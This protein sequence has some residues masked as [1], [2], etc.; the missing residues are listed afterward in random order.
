MRS[1]QQVPN[2]SRSHVLLELVLLHADIP[3]GLSTSTQSLYQQA[4][5]GNVN[6]S[7]VLGSSYASRQ[8]DSM[9]PP[10]AAALTAA[11]EAGASSDGDVEL[12]VLV[13]A[14]SNV[15]LVPG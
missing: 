11:G 13:S 4:T 7:M 14:A 8:D 9:F 1:S 12:L 15:P 5:A 2:T 10:A 3:G 6:H